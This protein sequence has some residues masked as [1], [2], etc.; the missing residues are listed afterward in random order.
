MEDQVADFITKSNASNT[1]NTSNASVT[2]KNN[3]KFNIKS[4]INQVI[5][6]S[7]ALIFKIMPYVL[8]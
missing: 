3:Q 4:F 2:S 5:K 6:D 8:I 1:N 7:F